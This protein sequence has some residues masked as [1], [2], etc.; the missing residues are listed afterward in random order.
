MFYISNI[1]NKTVGITDTTDNVEEFLSSNEVLLAEKQVGKIEGI[2][3]IKGR[4]YFIPLTNMTLALKQKKV[5]IPVRVKLTAGLDYKQTVYMGS[6][7][8]ENRKDV[9]FYF[10]DDS[11]VDGYFGVSCNYALMHKDELFFDFENNDA[12]RVATLLRRIKDNGNLSF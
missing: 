10:Y 4:I 5:G 2:L 7:F 6:K 1:R 12:V 11:G 8:D 3:R 9:V